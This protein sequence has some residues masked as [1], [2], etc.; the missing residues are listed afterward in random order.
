MRAVKSRD[1]EPE[2]TVRRTLHG[3]GY[4][5][6]LHRTDLPGTPDI[7]FPSRRK[8][9]LVHGC[10]WHQHE[11]QRGARSP[12]ANQAYWLAKLQRNRERDAAHE[13]MLR[14]LGWRIMVIW[15]CQ[16]R[17]QDGLAKQIT[18]FLSPGGAD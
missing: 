6:R 11:C 18:A 15:E 7:V 2:M 17:D 16:T 1:T 9:I 12:K 13:A 10:F 8:A 3:L 5:Y 14:E 4:R